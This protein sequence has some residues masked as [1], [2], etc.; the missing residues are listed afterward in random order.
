MQVWFDVITAQL[1]SGL[2]HCITLG[3]ASVQL[4]SDKALASGAVFL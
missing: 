3:T 1:N 4:Y 2:R